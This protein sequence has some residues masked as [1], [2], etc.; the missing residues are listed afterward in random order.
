MKTLQIPCTGYS[1]VA[2]VYEA[3]GV[4]P[5]LLSLIGRTSRRD[6][7]HYRDFF[8]KLADELGITSVI[9]DYSGHGDSP[10][11]IEELTPA[12]H[13][14]ETVTVFD[15]MKEQY[16]HRKLF[17]IGSSYGGFLATQ[18]TKYRQFDALILRAPA[19]YRPTDF[20]TKMKDE[21]TNVT[22]QFRK[23]R[24]ELASHPLLV[25]ASQ[26]KGSALLII[27][28]EDERIPQETTDAYTAAFQ[29]EILV[30]KGL[31]HSL[32]KATPQQVETYNQE[33]YTWLK[34]QI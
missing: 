30:A 22:E 16:P 4:G 33:I 8:P 19:I 21:D 26:F 25:R 27:H 32:S 13:F 29:P 3:R 23:N 5:L 9:F 1:V 24:E 20:Y 15:W 11:D 17:V 10:F 12:Q 31:P 7:Q 34:T 6:K 28:E 18:L 2:D 14:L